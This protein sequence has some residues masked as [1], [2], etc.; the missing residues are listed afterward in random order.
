MKMC[1]DIDQTISS[2]FLGTSVE[3]SLAYYRSRQVEVPL[4]AQY[5]RDFFGLPEVLRIHEEIPGALLVLQHLARC[6]HEISYFTVR[7]SDDHAQQEL[8][9]VNTRLWLAEHQ[10]PNAEQVF[11]FAG[12]PAKLYGIGKRMSEEHPIILIDDSWEKVLDAYERIHQVDRYVAQHLRKHLTLLAFGAT[13]STW[14]MSTPLRLRA[15]PHWTEE[16]VQE[17]IHAINSVPSISPF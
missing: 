9:E 8:I 2:G 11:F 7:H 1:V 6:G 10:F 3:E 4:D 17:A 15:L 14:P 12:M 13:Q 16:H 5:Y